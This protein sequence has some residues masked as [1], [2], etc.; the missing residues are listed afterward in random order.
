M[1]QVIRL[2]RCANKH[3]IAL[4][5]LQQLKCFATSNFISPEDSNYDSLSSTIQMLKWRLEESRLF[6]D[7]GESGA[8]IRLGKRIV[9]AVDYVQTEYGSKEQAGT[10]KP[11]DTSIEVIDG[12]VTLRATSLSE[13]GYWMA[14]TRVESTE[15]IIKNYLK[16]ATELLSDR[17]EERNSPSLVMETTHAETCYTL[18]QYYDHLYAAVVKRMNTVEWAEEDRIR[19]AKQEEYAALQLELVDRSNKPSSGKGKNSSSTKRKR[20]SADGIRG[21]TKL[22]RRR[23]S[24]LSKELK[25]MNESFVSQQ[26]SKQEYLLGA[27]E[28]YGKCLISSPREACSA[29]AVFRLVSLWFENGMGNFL[30]NTAQDLIRQLNRFISHLIDQVDVTVFIPLTPQIV[31]RLGHGLQSEVETGASDVVPSS[32]PLEDCDSG[33]ENF[34]AFSA[35]LNKLLIKMVRVQPHIVLPHLFALVKSTAGS[36]SMDAKGSAKKRRKAGNNI[37]EVQKMADHRKAEAA[38][39]VIDSFKAIN[40]SSRS[41]CEGFSMISEAYIKLA[42]YKHPD[43]TSSNIKIQS[44]IPDWSTLTKHI[45][46]KG[47]AVLTASR[48]QRLCTGIYGSEYE[49]DKE[50]EEEG[51]SGYGSGF[52]DPITALPESARYT[53]KNGTQHENVV[54]FREFVPEFKISMTG[55]SRPKFIKVLDDKGN[56]H[57]Q[58]LKSGDDLRQ[59]SV[60]QQFFSVVNALLIKNNSARQ[61]GLQVRTYEVVPLT[62]KVGIMQMVANSEALTNV[63]GKAH[64]LW[65]PREMD[66]RRVY[67]LMD[68]KQSERTRMKIFE[69]ICGLSASSLHKVKGAKKPED[70]RVRPVLGNV[71]LSR[72]L[73][74][75]SFYHA[76]LAYTHSVAVNSMT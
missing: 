12:L 7:R 49:T 63:L 72:N 66:V 20:S 42:Q 23:I 14:S 55:L 64:K 69:K 17:I 10:S 44:I 21:N 36:T 74:P 33:G 8:A 54:F 19:L 39:A 15:S 32:I 18:A 25:T 57:P 59:D 60:M 53:W 58:V 62:R 2:A 48:N 28:H 68:A 41:L 45:H 51:D 1:F 34:A 43:D 75:S 4:S 26:T 6:W 46:R 61:R 38:A 22:I 27:L 67:K 71:L 73:D 29:L 5:A 31:S 3:D 16:P 30:K 35:V 13:V 65:H 56:E 76:R 9:E 52:E 50:E 40:A 47:V 70:V 24:V 11:T 37:D